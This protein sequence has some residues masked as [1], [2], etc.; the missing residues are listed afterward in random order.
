MHIVIYVHS[1]HVCTDTVD[2]IRKAGTADVLGTPTYVYV[3]HRV[4]TASGSVLFSVI[5]RVVP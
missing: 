4:R 5:A 1:E 3:L 2:K